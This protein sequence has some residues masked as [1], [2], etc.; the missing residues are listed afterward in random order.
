[1]QAAARTLAMRFKLGEFDDP[2]G[3]PYTRIPK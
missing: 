3:Q 1:V 2:A